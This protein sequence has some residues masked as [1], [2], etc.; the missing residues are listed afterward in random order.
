M[1]SPDFMWRKLAM[2]HPIM[3]ALV[4]AACLFWGAS[5][6]SAQYITTASYTYPSGYVNY[7][8]GTS[9]VVPVSYGYYPTYSYATPYYY[10]TPYY[11]GTPYYTSP[12]VSYSLGYYG[13][14]GYYR[15]GYYGIPRDY[16]RRW[17]W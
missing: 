14:G 15:T 7:Y 11:Y 13:Y 12:S 16:S 6:A 10:T 9:S 8:Y 2:K 1:G 3:A 4:A 5:S 17:W